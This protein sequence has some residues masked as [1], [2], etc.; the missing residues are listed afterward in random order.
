MLWQPAPVA[1]QPA[2]PVSL[3]AG[4]LEA[5]G[6]EER[7]MRLG[8]TPETPE[9][10]AQF[11]KDFIRDTAPEFRKP[12]VDQLATFIQPTFQ[13][14]IDGAVYCEPQLRQIIERVRPDVERAYPALSAP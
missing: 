2:V 6:F 12:T 4:T 11:W 3:I 1:P 5:K 7:L 9:A 10:P 8:P 13:A 14:L